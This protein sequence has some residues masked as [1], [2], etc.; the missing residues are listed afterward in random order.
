MKRE[1]GKLNKRCLTLDQKN[2]ILDVVK[3]RKMSC[4]EIAEQLKI[5]KA[6]ATNDL[7]S[8]LDLNDF[9]ASEGWLDKW[10]LSYDIREKPISGESFDVSEVTVGFWMERLRELR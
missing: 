7:L 1:A 3:R 6:Q 4:R 10:K 9:K 8:N 5:G 2:K